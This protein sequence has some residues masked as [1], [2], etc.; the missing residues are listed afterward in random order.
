MWCHTSLYGQVISLSVS[1]IIAFEGEH[2]VIYMNS[3]GGD[4]ELDASKKRGTGSRLVN[5]ILGVT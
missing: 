4:L 3:L 2:R 5:L 1:S